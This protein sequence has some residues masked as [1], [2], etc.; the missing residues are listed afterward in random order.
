MQGPA[1][2]R[3]GQIPD[4]EANPAPKSISRQ[5][6]MLKPTDRCQKV[7]ISEASL[8]ASPTPQV[9]RLL[10]VGNFDCLDDESRLQKLSLHKLIG[11]DWRPTTC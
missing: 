6:S 2:F 7:L 10:Q 5:A 3:D 9:E 1:A 11:L 8:T 4:G